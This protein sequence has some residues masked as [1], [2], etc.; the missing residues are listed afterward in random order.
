MIRPVQISV[1]STDDAIAS[2]LVKQQEHF[3]KASGSVQN[4]IGAGIIPRI[5]CVLTGQNADA[6]EGLVRYFSKMGVRE[7]HFAQYSRSRFRHEDALF[8]SY[9]QKVR[10]K[11]TADSLHHEFPELDITIQQVTSMEGARN[12]SWDEWNGRARCS[13][14]RSHLYIQ[15]NGEVTLCEQV[16]HSSQ[17]V[18]GNVFKEG[19]MG[20][21]NGKQLTDFIYPNRSKFTGTVCFACHDFDKCHQEKGYCFRDAISSYGTIYEAQPE[22]PLQQKTPI[23]EI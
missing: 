16:P 20:V 1:D 5:K 14:G 21:W 8:L 18:I 10:L 7:F 22:C 6:T 13:G 9:E 23:R 11:E 4:L 3:K 15:P 2:R 19:V 12:M 17:F